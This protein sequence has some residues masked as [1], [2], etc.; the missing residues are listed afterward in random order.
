[1]A[2]FAHCQEVLASGDTAAEGVLWDLAQ[3]IEKRWS[4]KAIGPAIILAIDNLDSF[5]QSIDEIAYRQLLRI[6]RHGPRY[7]VW[8]IASLPSRDYAG[9][10]EHLLASFRT[11]LLGKIS[12]IEVIAL[13]EKH[14]QTS[15]SSLDIT[16]QF[17]TFSG[18]GWI[19]FGICQPE[20]ENDGGSNDEHWN[21]MV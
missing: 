8:T 7:Q 21:V 6:I 11:S 14:L 5:V 2:R 16:G 9:L 17:C 19:H 20:I 18:E 13:L 12:S 15:A 4:G 10:D 1:L 3:E